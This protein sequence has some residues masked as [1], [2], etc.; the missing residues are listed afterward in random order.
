MKKSFSYG[1]NFCRIKE[2]VKEYENVVV[3]DLIQTNEE[4]L[5]YFI[6]ENIENINDEID[7]IIKEREKN[8]CYL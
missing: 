1:C 5:D 3:Y 7:T 6:K 8:K 4:Y 2:N